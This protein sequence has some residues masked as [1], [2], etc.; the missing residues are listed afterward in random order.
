METRTLK[1]R[2]PAPGLVD[3]DGSRGLR[4]L[5]LYGRLSSFGWAPCLRPHAEAAARGGRVVA[6][7]DSRSEA[8]E[9]A[10][11]PWYNFGVVAEG[12]AP[13][14]AGKLPFESMLFHFWEVVSGRRTLA[15]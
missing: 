6:P 1:E 15:A 7:V 5:P 8:R 3:L 4:C 10:A 13:C 9:V 2:R 14:F 12:M 11:V